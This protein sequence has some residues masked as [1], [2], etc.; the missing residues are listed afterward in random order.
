[1]MLDKYSI[2][3]ISYKITTTEGRFPIHIKQYHFPS[4][5]KYEINIQ[6]QDLLDNDIIIP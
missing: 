5:Y 6:V 3:T 2:D 1:M 4:M